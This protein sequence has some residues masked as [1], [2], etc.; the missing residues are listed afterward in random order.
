MKILVFIILA[1]IVAAMLLKLRAPSR[2]PGKAPRASAT[3]RVPAPRD[4]DPALDNPYRAVSITFGGGACEAVQSIGSRRFL[5]GETPR[6]PLP[7]CTASTCSCKYK[8]HDDRRDSDAERR[9]PAGMTT[10]M[11]STDGNAERRREKEGGRRES[12]WE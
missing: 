11:Y 3:K 12:D 1:I 7:A 2:K 6:V 5:V 8:H 10:Q 9:H 4:D